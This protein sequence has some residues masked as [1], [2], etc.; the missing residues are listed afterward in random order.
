MSRERRLELREEIREMFVHSYDGYMRHAFPGGELLPLSC[1]SGE[2][3]LV[4]LVTLVDSLDALAIM[5]NATE[6]R[7]A[8]RC[9]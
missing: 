5:G 3:H 1:G 7:R 9:V 6:F 2:L 4:P 8:V